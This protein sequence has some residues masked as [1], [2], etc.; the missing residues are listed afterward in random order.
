MLSIKNLGEL[1]SAAEAKEASNGGSTETGN[2]SKPVDEPLKE[3]CMALVKI[4]NA[5]VASSSFTKKGQQAQRFATP[6]QL[7]PGYNLCLKLKKVENHML[8]REGILDQ[9]ADSSHERVECKTDGSS[10]S[11]AVA[12]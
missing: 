3:A 11:L 1:A 12:P 6:A 5:G 10:K 2:D 8:S 9:D 4:Y 7:G